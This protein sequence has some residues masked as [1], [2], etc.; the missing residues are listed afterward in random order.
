MISKILLMYQRCKGHLK[1]AIKNHYLINQSNVFRII[2]N[3]TVRR[4]L[5]RRN[6]LQK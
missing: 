4:S 6:W 1:P 5:I 3:V 2:I